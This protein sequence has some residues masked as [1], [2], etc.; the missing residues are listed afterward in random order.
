[1][2]RTDDILARIVAAKQREITNAMQTA[3]PA[4]I[5]AQARA[6][7]IGSPPRPFA[8]ALRDAARL[9]V[10]A[11][12]KRRSPSKGVLCENFVPAEIAA[13]YAAAGAACLS[14]LT[15][16]DFFGGSAVD[17]QEARAA[18]ELPVLRKDFML[19]E[20]QIYQSRAMGADAV[21]LIVAIL[22]DDALH[23]LAAVAAALGMAVL[24]E[25]HDAEEMRRAL[26]LPPDILLGI[27]N[28]NLKTF[29]TTIQTTLDL[30]P[31]V[32]EAQEEEEARLLISESG[33]HQPE[34]VRELRRAGVDAFLIGEAL[35]QDP[36]GALT[37]LFKGK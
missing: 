19:N 8:A 23:A 11:E 10:I 36:Q 9:P 34:E 35:V 24:V 18:C 12:I 15:D 5:Q 1:M 37:R 25:V 28:R 2:M 21:L 32:R 4:V 27:N 3:P 31:Q 26:R 29:E 30:L 33:V 20:W 13:A 16:A 6:Q 14:V 7:N 17:L 22:D